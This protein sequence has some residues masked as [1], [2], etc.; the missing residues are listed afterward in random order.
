MNEALQRE[1]AAIL[2]QAWLAG[3][4]VTGIPEACR[5]TTLDEG[6]VVQGRLAELSGDRVV[7]WK[8]AASST[9]GQ[10]H[11][12][13]DGPVAGRLLARFVQEGRVTLDLSHCSMRLA[14]VEFAF[15]MGRDLTPRATPYGVD[16][17]VAAVATLH[18]GLEFPDTRYTEVT[19]AGAAQ[20]VADTACAW[21]FVYGA[22]MPDTW[23]TLD[24]AA[25]KVD[26]L[27]DGAVI[28]EGK[29]GNALGDPRISLAWL[30][31]E[32]S[33]QGLTLRTGDI[34]TTGTCI[35]PAPVKPGQSIT[36]RY[37][38]LGALTVD[39]AQ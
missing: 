9:A 23:R 29:G 2:W 11:I 13:V 6:Y 32:L 33:R 20:I 7:G 28:A 31:N 34:V 15:R 16:E 8:V 4:H 21:R 24:L 25:Q 26:L 5:P 37:E 36:A 17:V 10:K 38:G 12:G 18:S 3:N 27:A 30:A 35:V 39:F 14:E 19:R 22:A 1:A